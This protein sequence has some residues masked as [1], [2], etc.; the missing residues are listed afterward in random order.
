MFM[1]LSVRRVKAGKLSLAF[2]GRAKTA[3]ENEEC[4]GTFRHPGYYEKI[5]FIASLNVFKV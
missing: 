5:I 3:S 1:E 2:F 4:P